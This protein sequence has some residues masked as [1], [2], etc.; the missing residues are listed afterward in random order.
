MVRFMKKIK[1]RA[2]RYIKVLHRLRTELLLVAFFISLEMLWSKMD[3]FFKTGV[4]VDKLFVLLEIWDFSFFEKKDMVDFKWDLVEKWLMKVLRFFLSIASFCAFFCLSGLNLLF[5]CM[6]FC[7]ML[8]SWLLFCRRACLKVL[9][10]WILMFL[11][12][13]LS[14]V[15]CESFTSNSRLVRN[16]TEQITRVCIL[17]QVFIDCSFSLLELRT[18]DFEFSWS[19]ILFADMTETQIKKITRQ[20]LN[21]YILW[22]F[23]NNWEDGKKLLSFK[24]FR[25]SQTPCQEASTDTK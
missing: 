19:T 10:F 16:I 7:W 18:M 12:S 24:D 6:L 25:R 20:L 14:V 4:L 1:N 17:I 21:M 15:I 13:I 9:K 3:S 8:F 5:C 22:A 23:R 2:R 11:T